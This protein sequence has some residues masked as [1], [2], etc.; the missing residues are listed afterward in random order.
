MRMLRPLLI[1]TV[2]TVALAA[3]PAIVHANV[4][5]GPH[6]QEPIIP[7]PP[8]PQGGEPISPRPPEPEPEPEPGHGGGAPQGDPVSGQPGDDGDNTFIYILAGL[9]IFGFV[10]FMAGRRESSA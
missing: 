6:V 10:I 7:R 9:A 8:V 3:A 5:V 2:A 1:V 4:P